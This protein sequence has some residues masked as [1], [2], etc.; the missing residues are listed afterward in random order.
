MLTMEL[1][2]KNWLINAFNG[3]WIRLENPQPANKVKGR[4][5]TR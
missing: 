4:S 2:L 1:E 3:E 5:G